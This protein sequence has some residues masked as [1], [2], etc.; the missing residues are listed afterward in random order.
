MTP[1][2]TP[3]QMREIDAA[4]DVDVSV[5]VERA[6]AE[7]ARQALRLLG[8]TYGRRAI[9]VAGPGNNGA[10]GRVAARRLEDRG[11]RCVVVDA[12]LAPD[13]LDSADLVIDAAFGTGFRGGWRF[14]DVGNTPVLAVDV[15]T[16]L[17][18]AS[19]VAAPGTPRATATVTFAAAKPGHYFGDGPDRCGDLVVADIGLDVAEPYALVVETA[20]VCGWLPARSARSHKWREAVRVVAG[21]ADMPGAAYL[22]AAAAQRS[23]ASLVALSTPGI[24]ASHP[25]ET[26]GRRI[27]SSNW[28]DAVLGDLHRYRALVIGPGLGRDDQTIPSV[29]RTV[30]EAVVPVVVDGDGLFALCW[31]DAGTPAFLRDREVPTIL[32]PH[33]GEYE[34][35]MGAAPTAD[36]IAAT[37]SLVDR[38]GAT[39]LLKGPTTVV[40]QPGSTPWLVTSGD[41][42]LATAGTGDV[43]SGIIGALLA[44]RMPPGLAAAAGAHVHGLA[45]AGCPPFGMVASDLI[46]RLPDVLSRLARADQEGSA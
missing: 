42:R 20:D 1:V 46:E 38:S 36:R 16:G 3:A 14:P 5:L 45:A 23:G 24:D 6:G 28:A 37:V 21:S 33:D 13:R 34:T 29:V 31:N 30:T 18:A 40:V 19:G 11:V 25:V 2:V 43:L 4:A 12:L 26:V 8:T 10:D 9:V 41:E 35:L 17:D 39:V 44:R 22:V 32:T 15:P 27:P 7:V